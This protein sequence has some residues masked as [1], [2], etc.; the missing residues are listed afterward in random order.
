MRD[1][2]GSSG[3]ERVSRHLGLGL[4]HIHLHI[5]LVSISKAGASPQSRVLGAVEGNDK[6]KCCEED[7][8]QE[9]HNQG[10]DGD[11]YDDIDDDD[12][13]EDNDECCEKQGRVASKTSWLKIIRA[14]LCVRFLILEIG[15]D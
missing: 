14:S 7:E 10:R 12:D 9:T 2:Y 3:E 5:Y 11:H 15:K 8:E 4:L 13:D 6:E 1:N